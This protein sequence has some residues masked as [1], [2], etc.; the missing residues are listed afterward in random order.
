MSASIEE[1]KKFLE[2]KAKAEDSE[3]LSVKVVCGT[4]GRATQ[5]KVNF[6]EPQEE[7]KEE[8]KKKSSIS[9]KSKGV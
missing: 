4:D 6:I 1:I 8:P 7:V 5:Y 9:K 3:T 2:E